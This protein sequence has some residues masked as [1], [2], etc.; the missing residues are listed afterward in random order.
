VTTLIAANFFTEFAAAWERSQDT[1]WPQFFLFLSLTLRGLGLALLVGIPAGLALTG[2][3]RLAAPVIAALGLLQTVPNIVLLA[4]LIPVLHIGQVPALFAAVVYSLFPIVLNTY[5]GISQT[6]ASIRDAARGMGMTRSQV[7]WHV[8]LPL[9]FP[10]LLAGVRSAAVNASGVVVTSALIGAGGLGDYVYNGMSRQ[11][12][13]LIWLGAV[14]ILVLTLLLFWALGALER[15]SKKNTNLGMSLG[16]SLILLLSAYAVSGFV[17]RSFQPRRADIV[18]GAKDFI[19]GQILAE[20]VK[21]TIEA[22]TSLHAE[23]ISNLGTNV[24]FKALKN[25]EIDLYPEYTGNLLTGKEALDLPVP[26]DKST[27]TPLVRQEME[28]RHGLILLETF[29]LNN[30]Y[31]PAVTSATAKRYN[32]HKISDLRRVPQLRVVVDLSFLTRPDGWRG[33]V[34]KY[35]LRFDQPPTQVSPNL[36]YKA[37]EQGAADVVIGFATDW[38]IESMKLV[39]LEDDRGYFPS[40]HAAPLVRDAALK[41]HPEIRT[42]LD[43]LGGKIDDQAMRRLNYQV[44]VEKQ[45]ET[46]VARAFLQQAGILDAEKRQ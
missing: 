4:L 3:P 18:I 34:E 5:V 31:A 2:L 7:L 27:I 11:D 24:I 46:E 9:G 43:S 16:C 17:A 42:A 12:S 23:I 26:A 38:Q 44:S 41:E 37:L 36:L 21:Q 14:P 35:E 30:T 10:V 20:I 13:G 6:P 29:G 32:L 45:S 22:K 19:E 1:F 28:R 40:Y 15:L 33:L 39:V 8:E 25:G